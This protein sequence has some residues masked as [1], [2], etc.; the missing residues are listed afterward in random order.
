MRNI[1][2]QAKKHVL[3]DYSGVGAAYDGSRI[4]GRPEFPM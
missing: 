2:D 1:F 4:E 3:V